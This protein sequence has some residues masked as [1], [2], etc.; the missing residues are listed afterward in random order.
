MRNRFI[1]FTV[2]LILFFSCT[3]PSEGSRKEGE[4]IKNVVVASVE[5]TPTP[6]TS[7]DDS[8][9][10]P[11]IWIHSSNPGN[12]VIIGT[13][14]KGGLATYNL[15]GEQLNYYPFGYMNNCD[16]RYGFVLGDETI[17]LLA[18]SNRS[19]QSLSLYKFRKGECW[20]RF[21]H[22]LLNR[23]CWTKYMA[24]ACSKVKNRA[25]CMFL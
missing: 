10:D 21:I 9:D 11:A 1:L 23:R 20:I 17:D 12:S 2:S 4:H 13:D 24:C 3:R 18:V 7:K 25:K 6:Q 14:K 15:K 19:T 22:A 8:A 5:T 16:L